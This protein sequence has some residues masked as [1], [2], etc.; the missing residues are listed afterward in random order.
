MGFSQI[1]HFSRS[2]KAG[3]YPRLRLAPAKPFAFFPPYAQRRPEITPGYDT[4]GGGRL[5]SPARAQRRPEITPGY[6][7]PYISILAEPGEPRSTK[8]GDYPRLRRACP[9]SIRRGVSGR[10]TKAGD[11]PRL[12]PVASPNSLLEVSPLN[13]GRRLPPATTRAATTAI[14]R[15][16]FTATAQRRPEITP[17]YDRFVGATGRGPVGPALN[18]GRRLP[19]ATTSDS[20]SAT[21]PDRPLNEGRRLPPATTSAARGRSRLVRCRAQR[22]PEITPG[23][24]QPHRRGRCRLCDALNE[25]RRLPP[26]TTARSIRG[27][28][29]RRPLNEGRRLPPATTRSPSRGRTGTPTTLN[30]GR[31]LPPATTSDSNG[32]YARRRVRSTKAGDYPRLRLLIRGVGSFRA[33]NGSDYTRRRSESHGT[34]PILPNSPQFPARHTPFPGC[35]RRRP[36]GSPEVRRTPQMTHGW[37]S[38]RPRLRPIRSLPS[39]RSPGNRYTITESRSSSITSRTSPTKRAKRAGDRRHSKTDS[40][41]RS[42]YFSHTLATRRSR[43]A[44]APSVSAMS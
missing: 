29:S 37:P 19:P 25:G 18:E 31:R 5:A 44:P 8:A 7:L 10:S 28:P 3:D 2:T 15:P 38:S 24:D 11:Y 9:R 12:R 35:E 4:G 30:E 13:E 42:P 26:A 21:P 14:G 22:R 1:A 40:W 32:D 6:D 16:G 17:G 41:T 43:A 33:E 23:Y 27:R 39:P 34:D 20:S 36:P